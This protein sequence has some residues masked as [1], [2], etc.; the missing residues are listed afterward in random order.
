VCENRISGGAC[1][2]TVL[3]VV[4][5]ESVL[6]ENSHLSRVISAPMNF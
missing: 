4:P 2:N 6:S 5:P 1:E 3:V